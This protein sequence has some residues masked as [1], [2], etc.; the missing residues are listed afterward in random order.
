[1]R[2]ISVSVYYHHRRYRITTG[3]AATS[4][5]L[6][7]NKINTFSIKFKILDNLYFYAIIKTKQ[8]FNC[9]IICT[10]FNGI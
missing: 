6:T 2:R 7:R 8:L 10:Y 1:M 3:R 4:G 9:N 5:V